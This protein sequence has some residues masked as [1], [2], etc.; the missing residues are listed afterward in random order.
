MEEMTIDF[1]TKAPMSAESSREL[2][3][4]D[5]R[6]MRVLQ[7]D[8]RRSS[9]EIAKELGVSESTVRRRIDWLT[10]QRYIQ[11]SAI[12]DPI[13][14]GFSIWIIVQLQVDLSE[15]ETVSKELAELPEVFFIATTTGAFNIY[16][17]GVFTS[18]EHVYNF[19]TTK[20]AA[21]RGIR[22]S[23]SYT[24]LRLAKRTFALADPR[25]LSAEQSGHAP[26]QR[27]ESE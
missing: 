21:Y 10:E 20:L 23:S 8:G 1:V 27:G 5:F 9:T 22:N 14:I 18:N 12:C 19:M 6:L 17:T 7:L 2:T 13:R 24:I 15:I 11:I 16:F 25:E 3:D 4:L 26:K